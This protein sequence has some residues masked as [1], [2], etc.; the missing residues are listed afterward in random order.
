MQVNK[1]G[2]KPLGYFYLKLTIN[3]N[4][5]KSQQT[6]TTFNKYLLVNELFTRKID[7]VFIRSRNV[8]FNSTIMFFPNK[9]RL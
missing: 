5:K 7:V 2:E 9:E 8:S 3:S 6:P 1:H 4:F